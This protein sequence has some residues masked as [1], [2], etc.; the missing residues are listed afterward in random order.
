MMQLFLFFIKDYFRYFLFFRL[1]TYS[2]LV[3]LNFWILIAPVTLCYDWQH[4]SIPLVET[5]LDARNLATISVASV[6][7]YILAF[8]FLHFRKVPAVYL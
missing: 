5:L 6:L 1:L 3:S 2:Y 4:G 8:S 7:I